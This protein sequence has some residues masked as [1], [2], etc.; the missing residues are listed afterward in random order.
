M[1]STVLVSAAQNYMIRGGRFQSGNAM[2]ALNPK[3]HMYIK[4]M[5]IAT[6]KK[7]FKKRK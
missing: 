7:T 3:L 4:L 1:K 6:R 5:L 2:Y